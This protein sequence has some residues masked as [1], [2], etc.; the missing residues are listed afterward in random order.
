[1]ARLQAPQTACKYL[2][3]SPV[4]PRP[5]VWCTWSAPPV[6]TPGTPAW[7]APRLTR[8]FS[9]STA[10]R[11]R[12]HAAVLPL[13]HALLTPASVRPDRRARCDVSRAHA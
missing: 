13:A 9:A 5:S 4:T 2:G 1:M 12:L 6:H 3:S 11:S 8:S 7:H 10:A